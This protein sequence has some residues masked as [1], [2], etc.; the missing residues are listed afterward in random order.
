MINLC[1]SGTI[2]NELYRDGLLVKSK[3]ITGNPELAF[4]RDGKLNI[5]LT[6]N[7]KDSI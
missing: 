2:T 4:F 7:L 5:A 1:Y 6:V 3:E